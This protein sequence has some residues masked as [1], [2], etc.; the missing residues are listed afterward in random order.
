MMVCSRSSL[1]PPMPEPRW[2]PTASISSMKTMHGA[3][4]LAFSNR[5]AHARRA[6]ADEELDKLGRGAGEEG[7]ASLTGDRL[8]EERLTGTRGTD[9][10]ASLGDLRAE[11]GVLVGVL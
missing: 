3:L 11:R 4:D 5:V 8:R 7:H 10:E 2:R 1:P 6:D 9:E